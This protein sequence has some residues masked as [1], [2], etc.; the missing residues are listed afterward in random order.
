MIAPNI[1]KDLKQS[2][3]WNYHEEI[4]RLIEIFG[5]DFIK[6]QSILNNL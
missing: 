3:I 5:G 6:N 1:K 2:K 4:I